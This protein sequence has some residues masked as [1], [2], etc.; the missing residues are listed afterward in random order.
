MRPLDK[1]KIENLAVGSVE[2]SMLSHKL[3]VVTVLRKGRKSMVR[4]YGS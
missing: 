2:L 4:T 1:E 3:P